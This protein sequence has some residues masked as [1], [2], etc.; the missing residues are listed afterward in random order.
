MENRKASEG[1]TIDLVAETKP[2][3]SLTYDGCLVDKVLRKKSIYS[4]AGQDSL[5]QS[6]TMGLPAGTL[7]GMVQVDGSL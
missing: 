3:V 2:Y 6:E 7:T 4:A 5:P 1:T